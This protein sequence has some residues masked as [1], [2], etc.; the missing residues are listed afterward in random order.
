MQ[1]RLKTR[2]TTSIGKQKKYAFDT[3]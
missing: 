1:N 3:D 2:V